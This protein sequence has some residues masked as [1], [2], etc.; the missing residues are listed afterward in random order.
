MWS[1]QDLAEA[2]PDTLASRSLPFSGTHGEEEKRRLGVVDPRIALKKHLLLPRL[3]LQKLLHV[4]NLPNFNAQDL[5][6]LLG[7]RK[8][9]ITTKNNSFRFQHSCSR[10][11]LLDPIGFN[12]TSI[13]GSCRGAR[14][15]GR[16][17]PMAPP[18]SCALRPT[19]QVDTAMRCSPGLILSWMAS[20]VL[21]CPKANNNGMKGSP[22]SPPSPCETYWVPISSSH[23]YVDGLW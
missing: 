8:Q 23:K 13:P 11:H 17:W 7:S 2:R 22:C 6:S 18:P 14:G 3:V 1:A 19:A 10:G 15:C 20:R 4:L 12:A 16:V 21:C 9:R 5:H